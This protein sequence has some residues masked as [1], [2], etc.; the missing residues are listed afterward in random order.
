MKTKT[1]SFS[2]FITFCVLALFLI[3]NM[4]FFTSCDN[5]N[6][7][8]DNTNEEQNNNAPTDYCEICDGVQTENCGIEHKC[9]DENCVEYADK[10]IYKNGHTHDYCERTDCDGS[11]HMN[12]DHP[13]GPTYPDWFEEKNIGGENSPYKIPCIND[14]AYTATIPEGGSIDN[15]EM[16]NLYNNSYK[17][18]IKTFTFSDNFK[19]KFGNI[20]DEITFKVFDDQNTD[21]LIHYNKNFDYLIGSRN[22]NTAGSINDVCAP[23]FEEITKNIKISEDTDIDKKFLMYSYNAMKNF[24]YNGGATG[25]DV[26]NADY[27]NKKANIDVIL[28]RFNKDKGTNFSI[29]EKTVNENG[30]TIYGEILPEVAERLKLMFD[31]AAN[32]LDIELSDIEN[33]YNISLVSSSA[34][35]LRDHLIADGIEYSNTKCTNEMSTVISSVNSE[36]ISK[37]TTKLNKSIFSQNYGRELC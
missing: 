11:T 4:I 31:H 35:G 14:D 7:P 32:N 13:T 28:Q 23:I 30:E 8:N 17:D 2:K 26:N 21:E 6:S 24:A 12:A 1:D 29:Y 3:T 27:N 37:T 36:Y 19:Q 15:I 20:I 33:L 34:E 9:N 25:G 18:Y 16:M 22:D 10:K 5:G